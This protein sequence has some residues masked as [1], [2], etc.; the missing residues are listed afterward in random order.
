[1]LDMLGA[2]LR[3]V[4]DKMVDIARKYEVEGVA[5]AATFSEASGKIF[6][7]LKSGIDAIS[8]INSGNPLDA[9]KAAQFFADV[10]AVLANAVLVSKQQGTEG[11]F[12]FVTSV[13]EG[14]I[15]VQPQFMGFIGGYMQDVMSQGLAPAYQMMVDQASAAGAAAGQAWSA[16]FAANASV[17]GSQG[18]KSG[19]G[20]KGGNVPNTGNFNTQGNI[21][22][23]LNGLSTSETTNRV[24]AAVSGRSG[25]WSSIGDT[26]GI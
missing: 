22:V 5:A 11:G 14:M 23:N 3:L 25:N 18:G 6:T 15:A 19:P 8:N 2:D 12:A 16:A 24:I 9:A 1:M 4:V 20:D 26:Y 17:G 21:T 7:G 10:Q 13:Q